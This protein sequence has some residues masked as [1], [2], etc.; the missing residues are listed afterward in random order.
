MQKL[1]DVECP[2]CGWK[3]FNTNCRCPKCNYKLTN[4]FFEWYFFKRNKPSIVPKFDI[5]KLD[6]FTPKF[7]NG[8]DK[9]ILLYKN[10]FL[11][12]VLN[13]DEVPYSPK[14]I[15]AHIDEIIEKAN[16]IFIQHEK[17]IKLKEFHNDLY[18]HKGVITFHD[19]KRFKAKYKESY[20]DY[21]LHLGFSHYINQHNKNVINE[22]KDIFLNQ[23]LEELS[24]RSQLINYSDKEKFK[25]KYNKEYYKF[26]D[27]LQ[28]D[29]LIEDFNKDFIKK[30][31]GLDTK[32]YISQSDNYEFSIEKI[33][34]KIDC[35]SFN[36]EAFVN[37]GLIIEFEEFIKSP[38]FDF[39]SGDLEDEE[40]S[41]L[42]VKIKEDISNERISGNVIDIVEFYFEQYKSIK[43]RFSLNNFLNDYLES[44]DFDKLLDMYDDYTEDMISGIINHVRIDIS[45]DDSMDTDTLILKLEYYFKAESNKNIYF[46]QIDNIKANSQYYKYK[47][48]LTNE[49][50][51]G[52]LE[53][54]QT[55][56]SEGYH[57]KN[58][59]DCLINKINEQVDLN[60]DESRLKLKKLLFNSEFIEKN[61]IS[62]EELSQ[63]SEYF[64][65]LIYKNKIRSE[66]IN[67][68][69]LLL[70]REVL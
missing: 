21:Y 3:F 64:G 27:I 56:I 26:Y 8:F 37:E 51:D 47:Y 28:F 53:Y 45:E 19:R 29:N 30:E 2:N 55:K 5:E 69:Y 60:R 66:N 67:E 41:K 65:D 50:F 33:I 23:F 13:F 54:I 49:E 20:Y 61:N 18:N 63:I 25:S 59:N 11:K 58:L 24:V 31:R 52:I 12:L 1:T 9:K 32:K 10:N 7:I 22:E 6:I 14:V 34:S 68:S 46:I 38:I 39:V 15:W 43:K 48:G 17:K 44:D 70:M 16:L 42:I 36:G 40:S 62:S 57:I 4:E 35:A